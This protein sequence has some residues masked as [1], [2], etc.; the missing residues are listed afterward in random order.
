MAKFDKAKLQYKFLMEAMPTLIEPHFQMA[1][2]HYQM[3]EYDQFRQEKRYILNFKPKIMSQQII[4]MKKRV[5]L[6]N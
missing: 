4:E 2:L 6:M 1:K 5:S 3:K